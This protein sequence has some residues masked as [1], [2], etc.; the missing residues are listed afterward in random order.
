MKKMP[1]LLPPASRSCLLCVFFAQLTISLS[2]L[3]AI[4]LIVGRYY[5]KSQPIIVPGAVA[6]PPPPPILAAPAVCVTPPCGMH[7][8][9]SQYYFNSI[10]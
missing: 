3:K 4:S 9:F 5:A 7:P 1:P 8:G 10:S 6:V 2:S